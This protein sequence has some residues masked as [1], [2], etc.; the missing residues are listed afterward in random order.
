[1]QEGPKRV[2]TYG[3]CTLNEA[4][5]RYSAYRRE[6]LALKWAVTEKFKDYLYGHH[7]HV[8][9]DSNPLTYVTSTAKLNA[10]THRYYIVSSWQDKQRRG[11]PVTPSA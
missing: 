7:F 3:S 11:R 10:T 8:L 4:E 2:I 5:K 9:T 1:M 6:F